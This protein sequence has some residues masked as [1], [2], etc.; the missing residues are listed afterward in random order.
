M[1]DE[2]HDCG[3][4]KASGRMNIDEIYNGPMDFDANDPEA[5]HGRPVCNAAVF[6]FLTNI[7]HQRQ[8]MRQAVPIPEHVTKTLMHV[9]NALLISPVSYTSDDH[10]IGPDDFV[11]KWASKEQQRVAIGR[12]VVKMV[13]DRKGNRYKRKFYVGQGPDLA[14]NA[15]APREGEILSLNHDMEP[16]EIAQFVNL[17]PESA[18]EAKSLIPTLERFADKELHY[19]RDELTKFDR[20]SYAERRHEQG[21]P[22]KRMK[23]VSFANKTLETAMDEMRNIVKHEDERELSQATPNDGRSPGSTPGTHQATPGTGPLTPAG[24]SPDLFGMQPTVPTPTGFAPVQQGF[25]D[26]MEI[27]PAPRSPG[28]HNMFEN[29]MPAPRSPGMRPD[30]QMQHRDIGVPPVVDEDDDEDFRAPRSPAPMA[31]RNIKEEH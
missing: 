2:A 24:A 12:E 29:E 20:N 28:M 27:E 15:G 23:V 26:G 8:A 22:H 3:E 16:F 18:E 1:D 10:M 14:A 21:N 6:S 19:Y 9:K 7:Y 25:D 11:E 17:F 13:P 31:P 4:R 5:E 30:V